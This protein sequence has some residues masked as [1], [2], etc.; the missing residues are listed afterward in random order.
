MAAVALMVIDVEI[1]SSGSPRR[2]VRMS[3]MRVDGDAD[4]P[5]LALRPR[6]V[7]VAPHL[8]RAGRTRRSEPVCPCASR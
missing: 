3:S 8:R 2:S 6:V 7:G 1:L 4:A 5:D